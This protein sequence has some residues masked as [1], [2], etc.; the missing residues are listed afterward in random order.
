[1]NDAINKQRCNHCRNKLEIVRIR[2]LSCSVQH[3]VD[4]ISMRTD[5][6][7]GHCFKDVTECHFLIF[8]LVCHF[9]LSLPPSILL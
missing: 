4:Q 3:I 8:V 2:Q 5:A 6:S 7:S 1:M 9:I